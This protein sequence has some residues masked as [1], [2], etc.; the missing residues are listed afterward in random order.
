[1][2]HLEEFKVAFIGSVARSFEGEKY[3][4]NVFT[5]DGKNYQ[6]KSAEDYAGKCAIV[7]FLKEGEMMSEIKIA[8]DC[9][10]LVMVTNA[11]VIKT[12][13]EALKELKEMEP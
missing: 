5:L 4:Q 8:K 3:Y 1:M 7:K 9:F 11:S 2:K 6:A 10:T 12:A 13:K